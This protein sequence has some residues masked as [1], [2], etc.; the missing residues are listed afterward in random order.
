MIYRA[1][2]LQAGVHMVV[3]LH[4]HV[5]H[6]V[7]VPWSTVQQ[8]PQAEALI[9]AARSHDRD[10][11]GGPHLPTAPQAFLCIAIAMH[12]DSARSFL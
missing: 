12:I 3:V 9:Q 8:C 4:L 7:P 5:D 11:W 10:S 1:Q 6:A 2:H